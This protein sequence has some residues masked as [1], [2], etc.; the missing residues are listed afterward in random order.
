M[1]LSDGRGSDAG[2]GLQS[3][4]ER[5]VARQTVYGGMSHNQLLGW[6]A[7][8]LMLITF[9]FIQNRNCCPQS[10]ESGFI[11]LIGVSAL[12]CFCIATWLSLEGIQY[13]SE[14][15]QELRGTIPVFSSLKTVTQISF[16]DSVSQRQLVGC[17]GEALLTGHT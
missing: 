17:M 7:L 9:V 14:L 16:Y 8:C 4:L 12:A 13:S 11:V 1:R 3:P 6:V 2:T 15:L 10:L 5:A